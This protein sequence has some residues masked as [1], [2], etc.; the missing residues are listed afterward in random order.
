MVPMARITPESARSSI[1]LV[2]APEPKAAARPATVDECQR[3]AQW[4]ML[5]VPRP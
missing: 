4:S 2:I 5:L 1:E 3:R